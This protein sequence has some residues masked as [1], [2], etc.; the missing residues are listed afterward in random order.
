M[1]TKLPAHF[2]SALEIHAPLMGSAIYF[3][4]MELVEFYNLHFEMVFPA[5]NL[6]LLLFKHMGN[7]RL[8]S[9]SLFL[10]VNRTD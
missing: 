8:P 10:H 6:P 2:H 3:A 5:L 4:V 7:L 1:R 9:K